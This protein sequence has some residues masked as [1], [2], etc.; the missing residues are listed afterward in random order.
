STESAFALEPRG[1]R[2]ALQL[3][4]QRR[5]VREILRAP[6]CALV[7]DEVLPADE[8]NA[9]ELELHET[10]RAPGI[11]ELDP[12]DAGEDVDAKRL[13]TEHEDLPL[14]GQRLRRG[15]DV[16]EPKGDERCDHALGVLAGGSNEDVEILGEPRKAVRR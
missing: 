2:S 12:R 1:R 6:G 5:E 14:L 16:A 3:A 11:V 13:A 8:R 9:A 4:R 10:A 7:G 15:R